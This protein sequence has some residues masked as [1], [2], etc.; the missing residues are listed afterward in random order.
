MPATARTDPVVRLKPDSTVRVADPVVPGSTGPPVARPVIRR[1]PQDCE[2]PKRPRLRA[3][4][5]G[6]RIRHDQEVR[7]RRGVTRL[8]Q[9]A[10]RNH[11]PVRNLANRRDEDVEVAR[12]LEVL[13]AV[14]EEVHR[15][16]ELSRRARR[17]D[18]DPATR[19]RSRRAPGAPASSARR[20]PAID[21]G[22]RT[23]TSDRT[24]RPRRRR[25]P[26]GRSRGVRIDGR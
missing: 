23:A 3:R 11:A 8:A 12:Q 4:R 1:E 10:E 19:T 2:M 22:D 20:R 21:G 7:A 15:A 14:V 13:K 9:A 17:R 18:T 6:R 5:A 16:A 26:P 24:R 25:H